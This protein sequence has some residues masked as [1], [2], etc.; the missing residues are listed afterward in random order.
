ML[1]GALN[2]LSKASML[3]AER[4]PIA[5]SKDFKLAPKHDLIA[6]VALEELDPHAAAFLHRRA[7]EVLES[8]LGES[9][10]DTALLWACAQHWQKAGDEERSVALAKYFGE[11]LMRVGQ[12]DSAADFLKKVI[13]SCT[14]L[15]ERELLQRSRLH[16]LELANNWEA[17]RSDVVAFRGS[18]DVDERVHDDYEL[19]YFDALWRSSFDYDVLV[20]RLLVCLRHESASPSHRVRAGAL[21]LKAGSDLGDPKMM[22]AIFAMITPFLDAADVDRIESCEARL[23]YHCNNEDGSRVPELSK[24]LVDAAALTASAVRAAAATRNAGFANLKF[25]Y[26]GKAF[27]LLSEIVD[28]L[29]DAKL[30]RQARHSSYELARAYLDVDDTARARA[31]IERF[32][33]G[34]ELEVDSTE[35]I[36]R[37]WAEAKLAIAEN[38]VDAAV[39]NFEIVDRV[40][41]EQQTNMWK[42]TTL[43]MCVRL[44]ILRQADE[45]VVR[46]LVEDLLPVFAKNKHLGR[47]DYEAIS[48]AMGLQY[49]GLHAAARDLV[50]DYLRIRKERGSPPAK[51][52]EI[53]KSSTR[54]YSPQGLAP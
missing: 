37:A 36:R 28:V 45:D 38:D 17:I 35:V 52:L 11:H 40:P 9:T 8:E 26:Y 46:R 47:N 16:A 29:A 27:E 50:D 12:P 34:A 53:V 24:A 3:S 20:N 33:I 41:T 51:L 14:D 21:A 2:E 18:M 22:D 19:K 42:T 6:M 48:A 31:C 54:A 43:A 10:R 44:E 30:T 15:R 25:G 5:G 49:L 13:A 4:K 39:R 1:L 7:G 23:V 32:P